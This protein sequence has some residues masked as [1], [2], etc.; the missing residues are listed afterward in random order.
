MNWLAFIAALVDTLCSWPV[1]LV[2]VVLIFR[3]ELRELLPRAWLKH[4]E[5]E[6][7][8]VT[9]ASGR[10]SSVAGGQSS[11]TEIKSLEN[12]VRSLKIV[13]DRAAIDTDALKEFKALLKP[14]RGG[15][16]TLAV[17]CNRGRVVEMLIPGRYDTSPQT[18]QRLALAAG[19]LEVEEI[20]E[21]VA[22]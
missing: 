12:V 2:V 21:A 20:R 15:V 7:G 8:F 11:A 4:G 13:F 6:I 10:L 16:I 1:A 17:A 22:H 9:D 3:R 19:V 18:A 14:G 5:I